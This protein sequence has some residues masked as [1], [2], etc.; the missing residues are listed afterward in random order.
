[1]KNLRPLQRRFDGASKTSPQAMRNRAIATKTVAIANRVVSGLSGKIGRSAKIVANVPTIVRHA[2]PKRAK[3][4]TTN[5]AAR[6]ARL[7]HRVVRSNS[8]P[9]RKQQYRQSSLRRRPRMQRH[10][11]R[12]RVAA[13]AVAVV[14]VASAA[15]ALKASATRRRNFHSQQMAKI[16]PTILCPWQ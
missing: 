6:I 8:K 16:P 12:A 10:A 5:A 14:A 2:T 13:N 4:A 15:S 1:M 7:A 9:K 11:S 3:R